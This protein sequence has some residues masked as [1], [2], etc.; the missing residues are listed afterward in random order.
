MENSINISLLGINKLD[1]S[2]IVINLII[3]NPYWIIEGEESACNIT[4]T[5]LYENINPIRGVTMF[6]SL[7]LAMNISDTLLNKIS[8]T[9]DLSYENGIHYVLESC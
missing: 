4:I 3:S 5:P 6:Q 8:E 9:Y 2:K 7:K 1:N